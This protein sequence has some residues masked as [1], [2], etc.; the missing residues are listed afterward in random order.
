VFTPVGAHGVMT[1]NSLTLDDYVQGVVS[2]EMPSGWPQQ[3]LDAQA[4]AARTYAITA[5][6]VGRGYDVYDDTRSQA[7]GGVKAET[8]AGDAA[9]AATHGQVVEYDGRPVTTY[10]FASSGGQTES[11]QNVFAGN[12][13]E[14]WLVSEPDPYDDS[15]GNTHYR[16]SIDLSLAAATAK[17]G[18]LVRGQLVA[19]KIVKHGVSPRIVQ[20]QIVGTK[21]TTTATG[22]QLRVAFSAPSAWMAFKT[23]SA[24]GV[25]TVSSVAQ[26][27][28]TTE[29]T[30]E[31]QTGTTRNGGAALTGN[32]R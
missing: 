12:S 20:A 32:V 4:V 3:A 11:V 28:T 19:I 5:K 23:V 29:T 27:S 22:T 15:F 31:T 2:A 7:Y 26:G 9:V 6:A 25:Q 8:P 21:G 24:K 17:L 14:P 13:P 10:F 30:T 18:K 16:W 1:V